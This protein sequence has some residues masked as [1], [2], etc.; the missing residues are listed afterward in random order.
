MKMKKFKLTILLLL[1]TFGSF[2][3]IKFKSEVY[4]YFG[5]DNNIFRA[6]EDLQKN[7]STFYNPDSLILTDQFFDLGY[8]L[9]LRYKKGKKHKFKF[10]HDLWTRNYMDSSKLN[11]HS[12]DFDF[13]YDYKINKDFDMGIDYNISRNKK[14]GTTV[15]GSELTLP[16]TYWKNNMA[17]YFATDIIDHNETEISFDFFNKNYEKS[18]DGR[19]LD[20]KHFSVNLTTAQDLYFAKHDFKAWLDFSWANRTY[21]TMPA[22][23]SSGRVDTTDTRHWR[24]FSTQLNFKAFDIGI[25]SAK[26]YYRYKTRKDLFQDY[27]SYT[28]SMFGAKFYFENKKFEFIIN[29]KY[30]VRNY[31]VKLAPT[32]NQPEPLLVYKYFDFNAEISYEIST[33]VYLQFFYEIL[34]RD[35]NTEDLSRYTRRPYHSSRV[36]GGIMINPSKLLKKEKI[37]FGLD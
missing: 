35:T 30:N 1:S 16:L 11:Q 4:T 10:S 5:T 34:N 28:S 18:V 15:L 20:H 9:T 29:P 33:G 24:Y 19:S 27:F 23:D 3:Q 7:D 31:K 6:P 32:P 8:D 37:D 12:I 26:V 14:I 25:F 21:E 2:G 36:F 17:A 13:Q 22:L